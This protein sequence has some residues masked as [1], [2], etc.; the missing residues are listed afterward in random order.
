MP[1]KRI[2]L[3]LMFVFALLMA[4]NPA[5]GKKGYA[6]KGFV[7]ASP[8]QAASNT[9]V[10]LLDGN[11]GKVIEKDT[12]N[13]FG[14]YKFTGL[15]SGVYILQVGTF[16]KKVEVK[17]KD[18]RM[19]IDLSSPGGEMDYA[20]H[21][22]KEEQKAVSSKDQHAPDPP[23]ATK[24]MPN[25]TELASQIAGTWWGYQGSTERKIGLCRNGRY[26]DFT[27]SGYSG[28]SFDAGGNE[29]MAWGSASQGGGEGTWT[30]QGNTQQGTIYVTYTNGNQMTLQYQQCGELGCL[31]FNGN[32]LCRTSASCQ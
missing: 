13:F 12:T 23:N 8:T 27:E 9:G 24:D 22:I 4:T 7:G 10:A 25:N 21:Y 26:M 15:P 32:K 11:T 29:T 6:I 3:P 14:K 19:D 31:L 28:R 16:Q 18:V 30:I 2:Y 5:Y 17:G 20:G 1:P